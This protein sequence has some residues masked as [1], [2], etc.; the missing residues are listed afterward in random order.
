MTELETV[1]FQQFQCQEDQNVTSL[2]AQQSQNETLE[3]G[4]SKFS[5][6]MYC[7]CSREFYVDSDS[8]YRA[9]PDGKN[10]CTGWYDSYRLIL[11]ME[12]MPV[13]F[14]VSVNTLS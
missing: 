14:I 1:S 11:V 7:Y 13:Y 4:I 12:Q 9:F 2:V 10:Y 3:R 8:I 6:E 5:A